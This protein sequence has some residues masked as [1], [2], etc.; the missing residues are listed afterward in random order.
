MRY[1]IPFSLLLQHTLVLNLEYSNLGLNHIS[2]ETR[3]QNNGQIPKEKVDNF[4]QEF[5]LLDPRARVA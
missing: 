2:F 4:I 3:Y 1:Y 5:N